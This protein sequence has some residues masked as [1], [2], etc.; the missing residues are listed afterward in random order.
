FTGIPDGFNFIYAVPTKVQLNGA[1][2]LDGYFKNGTT[3][4]HWSSLK[5]LNIPFTYNGGVSYTIEGRNIQA[6][7]INGALYFNWSLLSPGN[8]TFTGIS[9]GFNFIYRAP[10]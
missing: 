7:S 8:V 6:V 5:T 3:Y 4:V 10:N 2:F 1:K 9:D